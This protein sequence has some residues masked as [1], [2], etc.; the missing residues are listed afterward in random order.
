M[1]PTKKIIV[2]VCVC[3]DPNGAGLSQ[4]PQYGAEG[5]YLGIGLEQVAGQH[6]KRERLIFL[7]QTLPEKIR[8]IK[9][10]KEHSEL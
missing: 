9:E 8:Q 2:C 5:D 3:R 6:L 1:G 7:T 4:W 10:E